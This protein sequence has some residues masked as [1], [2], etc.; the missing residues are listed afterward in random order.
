[1]I[2]IY[3]GGLRLLLFKGELG[4]LQICFR[5]IPLHHQKILVVLSNSP[6]LP[7]N[8][9]NVPNESTKLFSVGNTFRQATTQARIFCIY[10]SI[11]KIKP[12]VKSRPNMNKMAIYWDLWWSSCIVNCLL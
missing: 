8:L 10:C 12:M 2:F 9:K 7:R 3:Q 5:K 6:W 4:E 11:T 1:L